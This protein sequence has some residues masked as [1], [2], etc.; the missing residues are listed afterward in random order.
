MPGGGDQ[1]DGASVNSA[2]AFQCDSL[3]RRELGLSAESRLAEHAECRSAGGEFLTLYT[4]PPEWRLHARFR[5]YAGGL[6]VSCLLPRS[7]TTSIARRFLFSLLISNSNIT[8]PI[9]ITRTSPSRSASRIRL[10]R[11]VSAGLW[12]ASARGGG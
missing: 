5:R 8:G 3:S 1:P 2:H 12:I 6:A 11:R 9:P 10:G 7:S 4:H